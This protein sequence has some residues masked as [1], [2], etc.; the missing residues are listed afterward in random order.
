MNP[1]STYDPGDGRT[2][3]REGRGGMFVMLSEYERLEKRLAVV[4]AELEAAFPKKPDQHIATITG[5]ATR[6]EIE[7]LVQAVQ[8]TIPANLGE[9]VLDA[10]KGMRGVPREIISPKNDFE[11]FP[12]A[13]K[14]DPKFKTEIRDSAEAM[15]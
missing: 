9:K 13:Q 2:I 5:K 15:D 7:G 8:A 14:W 10:E 3:L 6:E 1:I 4:Q 11:S 12:E